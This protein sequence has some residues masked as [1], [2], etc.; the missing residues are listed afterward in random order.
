[1]GISFTCESCK[2]KIKAPD[3]AGGKWGNCPFCNHRCYIPLPRSADEEELTLASADESDETAYNEMMRETHSLTQNILHQTDMPD[4]DSA[5]SGPAKANEKELLKYIIIYL[6]LM[7]DG[8]LN[9]A[10]RIEEKIAPFQAVAKDILQRMAKAERLEPELAEIAP[11]ILK[12]LMKD[13]YEKL[14]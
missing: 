11:A 12:G 1:M 3:G 2:K 5:G 14:G 7:A 10:E 13:L 6:T 8:E 9:Q 4:D